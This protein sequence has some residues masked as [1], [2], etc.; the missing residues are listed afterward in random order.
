VEVKSKGALTALTASSL[1]QVMLGLDWSGSSI[2]PEQLDR[3]FDLATWAIG[4]DQEEYIELADQGAGAPAWSDSLF[5]GQALS[6]LRERFERG[7]RLAFRV[8]VKVQRKGGPAVPSRY[9][10]FLV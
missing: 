10:A 1:R 5:E 3:L 9:R 8:P 4:L 6:T 2:G 7:E